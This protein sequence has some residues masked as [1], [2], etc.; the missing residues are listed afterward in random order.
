MPISEP[1][2]VFPPGKAAMEGPSQ[3]G[4]EGEDRLPLAVAAPTPHRIDQTARV[5]GRALGCRFGQRIR[6][7]VQGGPPGG[8]L[9]QPGDDHLVGLGLPLQRWV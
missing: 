7:H 9:L 8:L 6:L 1:L 2:V 3:R 4:L 5:R